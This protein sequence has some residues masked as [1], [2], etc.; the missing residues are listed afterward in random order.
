MSTDTDCLAL[1]ERALAAVPAADGALAL[2][3]RERS[4]LMR[5]ARSRPTQAT[6]V[7]DV[8]VDVAAL[9]EGQVGRSATNCTDPRALAACAT[10]AAAAAEAASRSSGSGPYPGFPASRAP[11]PHQGHDPET[12]RLDPEPGGCALR[13]AFAA[14][15]ARGV[16]AHGIW[17][18]GEVETAVASSTGVAV[19]ERVTDAHMKVVCIAPGG[20]SGYSA[21]TAPALR[22]IDPK[23]TAECAAAKAAV[24]GEPAELPPGE[25]AVVMEPHAVGELLSLLSISAFNGLAHVEGR[26]ALAGRL[27]QRVASPQVNVSDSPRFPGTLPR[28]FDAEGVAKA[29]L[30][31]I[32]DGIAHRVVHDTRS[33]VLAGEA[34]TG[35]ALAPAGAP[36]GPVPTNV[37]MIGGGAASV[38]E[39]CAPVERGIYITRLWYANLVRPRQSLVTALSRDGTFLIEDGR[40]AGP[41]ADMRLT[42]RV[43]DMLARVEALSAR[44]ILTS[45]GEFYG[46]R[47][48]TGAVCPA[49]RF[50]GVRFTATAGSG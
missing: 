15:E 29:P 37:V 39:L 4:L 31:L 3:A 20:R 41:L 8:T 43:L 40:I 48:A 28:G 32:Q 22:S 7:D 45:E 26:G 27:G 30:P 49:V 23:A 9:R 42:D 2:V 24:G 47:F 33:A 18:A 13:A 10:R 12:A 34:T 14:A 44:S 6:S 25:H 17:T 11:R 46:R 35:H 1:A 21:A 38:E 36:F 50:T 16:E 19:A 5:Y